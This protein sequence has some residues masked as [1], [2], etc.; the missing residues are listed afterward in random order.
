MEVPSM[1]MP[2]GSILLASTDPERLR[3]WYAEVFDAPP[4]DDGFIRFGDVGVLIDGRDDVA[5]RS[6]EPARVIL[7]FHVDDAKAAAARMADAGATITVEPEWRGQAW[8]ATAL[9]PDGN[10]IQV[11]EIGDEYYTSRGRAAPLPQSGDGILARSDTQGRL[12]AQDLERARRF[13]AEKLGLHPV[14][15]REGGLRYRCGS[16]LF[17]LFASAGEPSGAHTQ[18]SWKVDDI[19]ATVAE[20]RGRGL[21]FE[22]YDFPGFEARDGIVDIPGTYPS[23]G[24]IGERAV[25]FRDSEGNVIGIGEAMH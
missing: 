21:E 16:T 4:D 8:F 7:N 13:Y 9:D 12:P 15:E 23:E 10:T 19:E 11:I 22:E 5:V 1:S 20:L 6:A 24:G 18:M 2:L 3:A 25:W 17:S 14:E